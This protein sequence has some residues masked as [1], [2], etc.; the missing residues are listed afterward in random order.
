ML[1]KKPFLQFYQPE[2]TVEII[3]VGLSSD[4]FLYRVFL[5]QIPTTLSDIT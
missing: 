5:V 1:H 3:I 2:L 4:Q